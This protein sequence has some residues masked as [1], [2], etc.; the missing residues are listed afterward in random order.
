[1][2]ICVLNNEIRQNALR[3]GSAATAAVAVQHQWKITSTMTAVT[4]EA[5]IHPLFLRIVVIWYK[6][7]F[8]INAHVVLNVASR[9]VSLALWRLLPLLVN[10]CIEFDRFGNVQKIIMWLRERQTF[11]ILTHSFAAII[12]YLFYG[13]WAYLD[14]N[15][16]HAF[17]TIS[18]HLNDCTSIQPKA[19]QNYWH[20]NFQCEHRMKIV[21]PQKKPKTHQR[22]VWKQKQ[23][24]KMH[25]EW[26]KAKRG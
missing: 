6:N 4:T 10:V 16:V 11:S 7:A 22:I 12:F 8:K 3:R 5:H 26:I 9:F 24:L 15:I 21:L 18:F 17:R 13:R 25:M 2:H 20:C 19:Q 1:M 14:L 23:T